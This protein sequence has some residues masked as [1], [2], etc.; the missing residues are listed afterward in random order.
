MF[1]SVTLSPLASSSLSSTRGS[2]ELCV[3][4][5]PDSLPMDLVR[6]SF[7]TCLHFCSCGLIVFPIRS[8]FCLPDSDGLLFPA[9]YIPCCI[10]SHSIVLVALA[11]GVSI[12]LSFDYVPMTY[13][14]CIAYGLAPFVFR[15]SYYLSCS[16]LSHLDLRPRALRV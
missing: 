15:Y 14:L 4:V 11:P 9:V 2:V 5:A 12:L 1:S 10:F 13:A 6:T 7:I 3:S 8:S 16:L